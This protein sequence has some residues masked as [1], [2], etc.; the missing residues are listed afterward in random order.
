MIIF[1]AIFN[2]ETTIYN[3]TSFKQEEFLK[4]VD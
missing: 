3:Y 1:L 4:K 2:Y